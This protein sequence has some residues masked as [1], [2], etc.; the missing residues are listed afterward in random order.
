MHNLAIGF[1][2]V[3]SRLIDFWVWREGVTIPNSKP[4]KEIEIPALVC[5]F[6]SQI[7]KT[8]QPTNN[9]SKPHNSIMSVISTNTK[10]KI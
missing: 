8:K 7:P 2:R 3:T 6:L 5:Y 1:R 9:L 10:N 4:T